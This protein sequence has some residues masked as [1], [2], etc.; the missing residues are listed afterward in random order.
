MSKILLRSVKNGLC[1][2]MYSSILSLFVAV[3][4]LAAVVVITL[5]SLLVM[6]S[7]KRGQQPGRALLKGSQFSWCCGASDKVK[8]VHWTWKGKA[9][10]Q[11]HANCIQYRPSALLSLTLLLESSHWDWLPYVRCSAGPGMGVLSMDCWQCIRKR[12]GKHLCLL[13]NKKQTIKV[14]I[15]CWTNEINSSRFCSCCS[16]QHMVTCSSC[17][18]LPAA[19][20]RFV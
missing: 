7:G 12:D 16:P 20:E 9:K 3:F 10:I 13:C 5:V 4:Q 8:S 17:H 1:S 18:S 2:W 6:L 15:F 19:V 11:A 14:F